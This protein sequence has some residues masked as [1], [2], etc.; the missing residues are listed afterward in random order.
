MVWGKAGSTTLSS[1]S[2]TI[3]VSGMTASKTNQFL[4]H[5]IPDSNN[6]QTRYS[7]NGVDTGG[8]YSYSN[9]KLGQ[10]NSTGQ[11]EN[12][13]LYDMGGEDADKFSITYACDVAGEEKLFI[14]FGVS[15][16]DAG[17]G[18]GGL[19]T[20]NEIVWKYETTSARVTS[21]KDDT[22][23]QTGTYA[24]DSNLSVLGSDITPAPSPD[25]TVTDG[26]I[27]YETDNNKEYVLYNNTWTEL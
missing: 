6:T 15:R 27:F 3:T 26:A 13:V 20:N 10:Y 17:S 5:A 9:T 11:D 4:N 22:S 7:V 14:G 16:K 25:A 23:A 19:V 12:N 2:D 24:V 21:V 18:S 1:T 8:K